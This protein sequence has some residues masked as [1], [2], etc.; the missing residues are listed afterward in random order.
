MAALVVLFLLALAVALTRSDVQTTPTHAE[1]SVE[2]SEGVDTLEVGDGVLTV[3]FERSDEGWRQVDPVD[4]LASV[5]AFDEVEAIFAA[6]IES[7]LFIALDEADA[8]LGFGGEGGVLVRA[9]A[10]DRVVAEFSVGASITV[11]NTNARR[12]WLLPADSG[13]AYRAWSP[14]PGSDLARTFGRAEWR[15][16]R[17]LRLKRSAIVGIT[18]EGVGVRVR[19]S[20]EFES[21][22]AQDGGAEKAEPPKRTWSIAEPDGVL[23]DEAAVSGLLSTL[24]SLRVERFAPGICLAEAGLEE[25]VRVVRV[26]TAD[27]EIV[28]EVGGRVQDGPEPDRAPDDEARYARVGGET[29]VYIIS[30]SSAESLTRTLGHLRHKSVWSLTEDDIQELRVGGVEPYVLRR[31]AEG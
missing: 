6:G 30:G 1:W 8:E 3:V 18:L 25:P 16:R 12:T 31:G 17:V 7:D 21:S 22:G 15:E 14:A 10:G 23:V 9:L 19:L 24:A 4:A 11:P 20:S 5:D 28:I 29:F 2:P 26:E 27:R 13:V